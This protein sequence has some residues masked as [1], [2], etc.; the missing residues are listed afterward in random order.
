MIQFKGTQSCN[1]KIEVDGDVLVVSI[2][3]G[4]NDLGR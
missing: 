4:D 3:E 1:K 2:E